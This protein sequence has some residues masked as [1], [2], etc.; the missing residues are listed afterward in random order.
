MKRIRSTIL[1]LLLIFSASFSFSQT[2]TTTFTNNSTT[3]LIV[4]NF[5]NTNSSPVKIT[6]LSGVVS[7]SGD[8]T[9]EA[10]Y[11]TSAIAGAPGVISTG[12]G[13]TQFGNG[14]VTGVANTSNSNA[15]T[16]FDNLSLIIPANTT[17]GLAVSAYTGTGSGCLRTSYF[18][19]AYVYQTQSA[20]CYLINGGN[21]SYAGSARPNNVAPGNP[22]YGFIGSV[23]YATPSACSGTP[24][25]G[26]TLAA[27]SVCSGNTILFSL[28][29]PP[30]ATGVTYQWQGSNDNQNWGNI[31]GATNPAYS[32]NLT[33]AAYYRCKVTCSGNDAYSTAK[34]VKT[35]IPTSCYCLPSYYGASSY[36]AITNVSFN[37]LNNSSGFSTSSPAYTNFPA[38]TA[39]TTVLKTRT[40]TLAATIQN[41]F[42]V[43]AWIDWNQDGTFSSTES[44]QINSGAGV[45]ITIPSNAQLGTTRMRIRSYTNSATDACTNYTGSYG[46]TEDYTITIADLTPCGSAS[47]IVPGDIAAT[48]DTVCPNTSFRLYLQSALLYSGLS[49][50]WQGSTDG[51]N[52]GNIPSATTDTLTTSGTSTA[53]YR[54]IVSCGGTTYTSNSKSVVVRLSPMCYCP[55][56]P[57]INTYMDIIKVQV[58]NMTNLSTCSTTGIPATSIINKYSD[59]SNV[60]PAVMTQTQEIAFSVDVT[61]CSTTNPGYNS[62]IA[63]FIDYNQDGDFLDAG[64]RVY[65]SA[66][67]T[68]VTYTQSGTFTVPASALPGKTIMRVINADYNS[69]SGNITGCLSYYLGETED[70]LVE[71]K[72]LTACSG[73]PV[74]GVTV[75][76]KDSVCASQTFQLTIPNL[77]YNS[78]YSY[79]WQ[80][81]YDSLSWGNVAN[82]TTSLLSTTQSA[83]TFYRCIVKCTGSNLSD[84]SVAVKVNMS[85]FLNCYCI[86]DSYNGGY[87]ISNVRFNTL[88]NASASPFANPYYTKYP[89]SV[90]TNVY[91]Q[92]AYPLTVNCSGYAIVRAWIDWN[93]N[94]IYESTESYLVGTTSSGAA[95]AVATSITVPAGASAGLTTMRVR[96]NYYGYALN[97]TDACTTTSY[98]ETEDY[99]IN[100]FQSQPCSGTPDMGSVVGVDSICSGTSFTLSLSRELTTTG[101]SYQWQWSTDSLNWNV[102]S[103]SNAYSIT[104]SQTA[105]RYYRCVVTCSN[106]SNTY[107]TEGKKV[108]MNKVENCYCLPSHTNSGY[109]LTSLSFN[110]ISNSASVAPAVPCY[111]YYPA[112]SMTTTVYQGSVYT[113]YST[114]N[115]SS[116]GRVWFDWNQNGVFETTESYL[117]GSYTSSFSLNITIPTTAATGKIRMRVRISPGSNLNATDACT[118]ISYG[119]TEDY[120]IYVA[121]NTACAGTPAPG[122]TVS[123]KN[124]V[125]SGTVFNLTIDNPVLASGATYQWQMSSDNSSW[126]NIFN[127]ST[128]PYSI[129]QT[130]DNYYRCAVT[131]SGNT[132]YST[133]LLVSMG[134]ASDCV[135]IP[136]NVSNYYPSVITGVTLNTLSNISGTP[137]AAPFYT[138]YES[139]STNLTINNSYTL[140]VT[141]NYAN[142][143]AAWFDWNNNGIFEA[144]EYTLL[145]SGWGSGAY[146]ATITVPAT[147]VPGF[148]KM[149]IRVS[150]GML[151]SSNAC[152]AVDGETED[153]RI[154]IVGTPMAI[155]LSDINARNAGSV[156]KINWKTSIEEKTDYFV[157]ERSSDAIHFVKLATI[158]AK[159]QAG[160]YA[161]TDEKAFKGVNYYRLSMHDAAGNYHYSRTVSAT[162]KENAA[163]VVEAY[164]NPSSSFVTV[165]VSGQLPGENAYIQLYDMQGKLMKSIRMTDKQTRVDINDL[166]K[167]L[168][169]LRYTD[170]RNNETI[171]ITKQ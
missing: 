5:Q 89:A 63:I 115:Y 160:A 67:T 151:A 108:A 82:A 86:G 144:S 37:T 149:R 6:G 75:A 131:C 132:G 16:F 94:G 76:S 58:A 54:V 43:R 24:S 107:T 126:T 2:I 27:D 122:N 3:G 56:L 21:T 95:G 113:F 145:S 101:L 8:V 91:T 35:S 12:N 98:G 4:F 84:T 88:S 96:S 163:L 32:T 65:A 33:S 77:S 7:V 83:V 57:S 10:W 62:S 156:N 23:T 13:W 26:N 48:A 22:Y 25:P 79:Q 41:Y 161:Y 137:G 90:S 11:K 1:L 66:I 14:S 46:E 53:Y 55:A 51:V 125:C 134:S 69:S 138:Y 135:C 124:N 59:Y 114:Q 45:S 167:G 159:G 64:E 142:Y 87:G 70:Y 100:V 155:T 109:Y 85:L 153:Y 44:Y 28:E 133:P 99:F 121:A 136:Q 30:F 18:G 158:A 71:I 111:T 61:N 148:I 127:A 152:T 150:S 118:S 52:W 170:T 80:A 40:Y 110:T 128:F 146:N 112:T 147:A 171:K 19:N 9:V 102:I 117:L 72:A 78:G 130:S 166:S 123:D 140:T 20:N 169:L 120:V 31:P 34:Y 129:S 139:P 104:V 157:L 164:P 103:S 47:S 106:G 60:S 92:F 141:K 116:Y 49:Y 68:Q 74:A 42:S 39:T 29:N 36:Y 38:T 143:L 17:Y 165:S 162:V 154:F 93:R 81:S 15:Q 97:A 50:Q 105:L 119:E 73:K 168:Y